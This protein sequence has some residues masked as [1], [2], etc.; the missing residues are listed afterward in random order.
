MKQFLCVVA[1]LC[2]ATTG[3]T[4]NRMMGGNGQS[5]GLLSSRKAPRPLIHSNQ[6]SEITQCSA[7]SD[8]CCDPCCGGDVCCEPECGCDPGCSCDVCCEGGCCCEGACGCDPGCGVGDPCCTDGC[9]TDGCCADGC[10]ADGCCADGNCSNGGSSSGNGRFGKHCRGGLANGQVCSACGDPNCRG[11]L[12]GGGFVS[13]VAS[14]YCPH[15]GGY[16]E[17][18]NFTPGPPAAQTAYPYY[19]TR[20]PRDFL[21]NN[22]PS[23]GPY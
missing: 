4:A 7:S 22:P 13:A 10:C 3:C 21:R 11:C 9:C 6:G 19:T 16:P 5:T 2:L 14:G 20:G 23:I 8:A 12:G 1:A 15:A 18:N 17:C